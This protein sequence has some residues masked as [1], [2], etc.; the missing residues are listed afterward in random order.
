MQFEEGKK[1]PTTFAFALVEYRQIRETGGSGQNS[2]CRCLVVLR[3]RLQ[4]TGQLMPMQTDKVESSPRL[5]NMRSLIS[6]GGKSIYILR[7]STEEFSV[8]VPMLL[9]TFRWPSSIGN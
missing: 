3:L 5:L 4:L 9:L 2:D 6:E 1:L 7:V 8:S